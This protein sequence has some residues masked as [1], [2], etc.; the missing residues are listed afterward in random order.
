MALLGTDVDPS[1]LSDRLPLVLE[2]YVFVALV[3]GG[4]E[5]PGWRWFALP[6][7]ETR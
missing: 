5:E 1:L 4:N 3:G 7:L 2:S 6:R